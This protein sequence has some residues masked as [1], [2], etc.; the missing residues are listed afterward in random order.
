MKRM[1]DKRPISLSGVRGFL[2]AV[3]HM[4]FTRAAEEMHISQSALSRQIQGLEDEIGRPLFL[5]NARRVTLTPVGE[6]FV[7]AAKMGLK[8]IDDGVTHIRAVDARRSVAV[9]TFDSFASLWLIPRLSVFAGSHPDVDVNCI[10]TDRSVDLGRE[11]I[12]VALRQM[13]RRL[14]ESEGHLLFE[15]VIAPVCSPTFADAQRVPKS[16][17]DLESHTLLKVDETIERALP[18]LSWEY[19]FDQM[20]ESN[21]KPRA[22]LRFTNYDQVIQAALSGQGVALARAPLVAE[23]LRQRR[24]L[25][26]MGCIGP[27]DCGYYLLAAKSSAQ[28]PEVDDFMRWIADEAAQTRALLKRLTSLPQKRPAR[29]R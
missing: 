22:T 29:R 18:W 16:A 6:E 9:T 11:D 2:F 12:D 24:L 20:G 25:M 7:R 21:V 13:R 5:R 10:A 19:W 3:R 28:R 15:E 4:S 8:A 27:V 17:A 26:P 14:P 1:N 23:S